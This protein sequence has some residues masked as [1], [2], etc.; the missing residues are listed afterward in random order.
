MTNETIVFLGPTLCRKAAK[1]LLPNACFHDPIRCGDI[2]KVAALRPKCLLIIDGYFEQ[3]AAVTHKE[4]LF[5]LECGIHVV[6]ASSMGALRAAELNQFGMIGVGE[7]YEA[8]RDRVI[9]GDDEVTLPHTRDEKGFHS[10]I[11][12]L[13]NVRKTL[14]KAIKD[15]VIGQ[16]KAVLLIDTLKQKPYF[17]R[18]FLTLLD[19]A[20]VSRQ[21]FDA[22]YCDIKKTDAIAA[23]KWLNKNPTFT[24]SPIKAHYTLF[25]KRLYREMMSEPFDKAYDWLSPHE[26]QLVSLSDFEKRLLK[27]LGKLMQIEAEINLYFSE[28]NLT[29]PKCH[30]HQSFVEKV[31][32]ICRD[33]PKKLNEKQQVWFDSIVDL[34]CRVMAVLEYF[35]IQ[36]NPTYGQQYFNAFRIKH[37][38][39][40]TDD[41]QQWLSD[42]AIDI[43]H[44]LERFIW[45]LTFYDYI[46]TQNRF[47]LFDIPI[48]MDRVRWI[49][50][51]L[52][53]SRRHSP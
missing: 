31:Y 33:V 11:M 17:D 28:K 19:Q 16:E 8:Y 37:K 46:V 15:N 45:V 3:T 50:R 49:A 42:H 29:V 51:A 18:N 6:G 14:D 1:K 22:N 7:V 24:Q 36:L 40:Q 13:V 27:D 43:E 47:D 32:R 38:L 30:I 20:G 26:Q 41:I 39:I 34:S 2:F 35:D 10:T 4:I 21:W 25:T 53:V 48:K 52:A 44:A 9:E 23:L 12:P 5:S